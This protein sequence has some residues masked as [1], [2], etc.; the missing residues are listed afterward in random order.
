MCGCLEKQ[1]V[2]SSS[3]Q[4][5]LDKP[6]STKFKSI[7]VSPFVF[8]FGVVTVGGN[9]QQLCVSYALPPLSQDH[10]PLQRLSDL[11]VFVCHGKKRFFWLFWSHTVAPLQ[12][13][14]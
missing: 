4:N 10:F 2:L 11:V 9:K 1:V 6:I 12:G 5:N 13:K 8:V 14:W 3:C 7:G